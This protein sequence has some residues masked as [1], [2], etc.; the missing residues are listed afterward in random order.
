M[1][2][3]LIELV[4]ISILENSINNF[5]LVEIVSCDQENQ[6]WKRV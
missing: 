4:H 6:I 5:S 1:K 2:K 3:K